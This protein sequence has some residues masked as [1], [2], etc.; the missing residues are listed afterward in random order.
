MV[1]VA[2]A[3]LR[4][5]GQDVAVISVFSFHFSGAGEREA[6]LRRG[7]GLYLRHWL[8]NLDCLNLPRHGVPTVSIIYSCVDVS[9]G[10]SASPFS[11]ASSPFAGASF[12][13]VSFLG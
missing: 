3:L 7:I 2:F 4:L 12:L 13:G 11:F 8:K 5:L 10:A 9:A 1:E 6:L